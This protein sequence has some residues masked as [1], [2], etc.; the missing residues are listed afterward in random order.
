MRGFIMLFLVFLFLISNDN[1]FI[2][3][4]LSTIHPK[5]GVP[6]NRIVAGE[7]TNGTTCGHTRMGTKNVKAGIATED[8]C[9]KKF[10]CQRYGR[11]D[12]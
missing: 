3:T 5:Q 11:K 7:Q 12:E 1:V 4:V 6:E 8:I 10:G 9:M 2:W